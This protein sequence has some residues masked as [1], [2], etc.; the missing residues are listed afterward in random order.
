MPDPTM[1]IRVWSIFYLLHQ[2]MLDQVIMDIIQV[3]PVIGFVS[4]QVF[5]I[6]ALPDAALATP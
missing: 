5:P 6:P 4:D 2:S 1:E 3:R